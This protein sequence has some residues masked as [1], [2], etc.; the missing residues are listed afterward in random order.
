MVKRRISLKA[1]VDLAKIFDAKAIFK[2]IIQNAPPNST[3]YNGAKQ[4]LN[5][6]AKIPTFVIETPEQL[7]RFSKAFRETM[8]PPSK[9][10]ST[11]GTS[12]CNICQEEGYDDIPSSYQCNQCGK[13]ICESHFVDT[14]QSILCTSC[15]SNL[16][17]C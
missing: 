17:E 6:I 4:Q 9:S 8:S 14:G 7:E 11:F 16:N 1:L 15:D 2:F 12:S 5:E 3:E 13:R 10:S